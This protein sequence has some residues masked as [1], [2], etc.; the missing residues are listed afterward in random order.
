MMLKVIVN[1]RVIM[2]EK[3]VMELENI[4]AVDEP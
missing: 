2:C 3:E 4:K 1:N